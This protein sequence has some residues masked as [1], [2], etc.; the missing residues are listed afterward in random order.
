MAWSDLTESEKGYIAGFLD[1]EGSVLLTRHNSSSLN[2]RPCVCFYNTNKEVLDWI[3]EVIGVKTDKIGTDKR[4][5]K[6]HRRTNY[7]VVIRKYSDVYKFLIR[8]RPYLRIKQKNADIVINFID[9]I[10]VRE[11]HKF[12]PEQLLIG[13]EYYLQLKKIT[14]YVGGD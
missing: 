4:S 1:G 13:E 14:A 3:S 9:E 7:Q 2:I 5:D 10:L 8:V 12:T 6:R 11:N